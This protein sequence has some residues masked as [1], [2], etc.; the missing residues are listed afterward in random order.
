[1][2]KTQ[3][4]HKTDDETKIKDKSPKNIFKTHRTEA[5]QIIKPN[6]KASINNDQNSQINSF[7]NVTN[8][9]PSTNNSDNSNNNNK[10]P[11]FPT[12]PISYFDV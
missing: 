7:S 8:K 12:R 11:F 1:M 4:I 6:N 10:K 3:K 5:A 2:D 9:S